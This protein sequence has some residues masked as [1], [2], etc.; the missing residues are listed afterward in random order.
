MN[1]FLQF[2]KNA[3]NWRFK[4]KRERKE[5]TNIKSIFTDLIL[6]CVIKIRNV[7]SKKELKNERIVTQIFPNKYSWF[8]NLILVTFSRLSYQLL[9][10]NKHPIYLH[11]RCANSRWNDVTVTK[12]RTHAIASLLLRRW[13]ECFEWKCSIRIEVTRGRGTRSNRSSAADRRVA[14]KTIV[15]PDIKFRI[16]KTAWILSLVMSPLL[17]L[18]SP[19]GSTFR[20]GGIKVG[21]GRSNS[22]S[23][24]TSTGRGYSG[25]RIGEGRLSNSTRQRSFPTTTTTTVPP[26]RFTYT[27]QSSMANNYNVTD[28]KVRISLLI[29][30]S[31][32]NCALKLITVR[33]GYSAFCIQEGNS[34][35]AY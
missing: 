1:Y 11:F 33:E 9:I 15:A 27:P 6:R 26:A 29:P 28:L 24:N 21:T 10:T 25:V 31:S 7:I 34:L 22:V 14:A 4:R 23:K 19:P 2:I 13:K 12:I 8:F 5:S 32:N 18:G 16:M 35:K 20:E 17:V 30:N 3:Y